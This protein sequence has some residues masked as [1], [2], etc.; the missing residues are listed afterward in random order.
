MNI[1]LLCFG[2]SPIAS[3]SG[4]EKVF[5]EMSNAFVERG[6]SVSAIWNDQPKIVPYYPF[7][8]EVCQVNLGLGK[9][10]APLKYKIMRE[11]N[12]CLNIKAV[13]KVDQYKTNLLCSALYKIID[14][15]K[16][17]VFVCYEFNSVMVANQLSIGRIPV[18]AMVHNSV[19]DQIASLTPL[20]RQEANKADV[21][22]VLMPNYVEQAKRLL[23]TKICYIPNIVPRVD[24]N[25]CADLAIKKEKYRIIHIGRIEGKQKRQ[26][27]LLKS[28]AKLSNKFPNWEVHFYGPIGDIQY[29]L[30]IENFIN[31]QQLNSKIFY[32]GITHH[33][34]CELRKGDIFAFPSAYEGFS[35]ALT[36]A[37]SAGLPVIGFKDAPSVQNLIEDGEN[38]YLAIDEEDFTS[39]LDYLMR[40]QTIRAILGKNA[41]KSM[42]KYAPN[43]IWD[44][45]EQL[46]RKLVGKSC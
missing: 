17:D 15:A 38:G 26:L 36:E 37:M 24:N 8:S 6:H 19:E 27:I 11:V 9:I 41:K 28:F 23:D 3:V 14:L 45:W 25:Q 1:A 12:K 39:K 30:Q 13:N 10:K 20:Q 2:I 46:L 32:E 31:Q 16:I 44:I 40:H 21:Y 33:V 42:E 18:V 5:V 29:K 43:A 7:N 4:M 34:F 35:L 22:Q